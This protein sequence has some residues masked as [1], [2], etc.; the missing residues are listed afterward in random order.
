[1]SANSQPFSHPFLLVNTGSGGG[2]TQQ[3]IVEVA[4]QTGL[5]WHE[6]APGDDFDAVLAAA[7]SDGADVLIGAGGDGTLSTVADTA[8]AHDLPMIAVPAGTRNHFALDLG[9][10]VDDPVSVLRNALANRFERRVD[11]GQVNGTTFLNN[12]S[13]GVYAQAVD[14]P[15]YRSHKVRALA[16]AAAHALSTGGT[17]QSAH[18][19]IAVPGTAVVDSPAGTTAL[20]IS[21]NAYAPRFAPGARLRSRLDAGEVWVYVGGGLDNAETLMGNVASIVSA[22]VHRTLLRAAFGAAEVNVAAD[23]ADVP[24]AIDGEFRP[25]VT[26]PF[27]IKSRAGA[28]RLIVGDDPSATDIGVTLQW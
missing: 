18:L 6:T 22:E 7:V 5:T 4:R 28:L 20:L 23:R 21:N 14:D 10:A 13:I 16:A 8:M 1:M 27:A 15:T 24:I 2:K 3:A 17:S 9:L 12:I 26:A 11:I 19:T 25:D